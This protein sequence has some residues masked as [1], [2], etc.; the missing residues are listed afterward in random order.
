[1]TP[2]R[3][4]S[5]NQNGRIHKFS[6]ILVSSENQSNTPWIYLNVILPIIS[7]IWRSVVESWL[8]AIPIGNNHIGQNGRIL[9]QVPRKKFHLQNM[10]SNAKIISLVKPNLSKLMWT[11]IFADE[12]IHHTAHL[13]NFFYFFG[14]FSWFHLAL[15]RGMMTFSI[16]GECHREIIS[17]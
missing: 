7:N 15:D 6:L 16:F 10:P 3:K 2:Q 9:S 4:Q 11:R 17:H 5:R 12:K 14:N 1:M 8:R 13:I